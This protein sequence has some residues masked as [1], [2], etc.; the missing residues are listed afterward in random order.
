MSIGAGIT[1]SRGPSMVAFQFN[2]ERLWLV[3]AADHRGEFHHTVDRGP[4]NNR[5]CNFLGTAAHRRSTN[6]Y[7][8]RR[9]LQA[10][11]DVSEKMVADSCAG[12]LVLRSALSPFVAT[13]KPVLDAIIRSL[14]VGMAASLGCCDLDHKPF[15]INRPFLQLHP[16]PFTTEPPLGC[17]T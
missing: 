8:L 1:M 7:A 17:K 11:S 6:A 5:R 16:Y 13:G 4:R 2:A 12:G 14:R 9:R 3:H 10:C 15:R